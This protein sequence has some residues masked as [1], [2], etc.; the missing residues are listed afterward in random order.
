MFLILD[1]GT[2]AKDYDC[3]FSS[4]YILYKS[5]GDIVQDSA[6]ILDE[7]IGKLLVLNDKKRV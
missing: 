1:K 6:Y 3:V 4:V 5:T 7:P 2:T